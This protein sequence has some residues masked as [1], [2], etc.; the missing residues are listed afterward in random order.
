MHSTD[1]ASGAYFEQG[2]S[3]VDGNYKFFKTMTAAGRRRALGSMAGQ[4]A[5]AAN[6]AD[7]R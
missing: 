4:H 3:G 5:G 2:K 6:S 1:S 7:L